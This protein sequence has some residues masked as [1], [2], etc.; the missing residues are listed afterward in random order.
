MQHGDTPQD[1][2]STPGPGRTRSELVWLVVATVALWL[3]FGVWVAV[4]WVL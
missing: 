4:W 2:A 1:A 3:A